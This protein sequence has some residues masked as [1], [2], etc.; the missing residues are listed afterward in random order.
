MYCAQ[1]S[2]SQNVVSE[3]TDQTNTEVTFLGNSCVRPLYTISKTLNNQKATS[4]MIICFIKDKLA[5]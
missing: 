4:K 2:F 5:F 1:S 3:I